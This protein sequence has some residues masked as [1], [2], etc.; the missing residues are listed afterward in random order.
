[1]FI[2]YYN[3]ANII[4]LLGLVCSV[5]SCY[6][7]MIGQL[8]LA[9]LVFL[10]AGL[11][12]M[13]DGRIARK[14]DKPQKEKLFGVQIDSLC[15]M[16][17]FGITPG[18]IAYCLGFDSIIDIII[19]IFFAICGAIRL[20]YFNTQALSEAENFKMT[21]FTGVPIPTICIILPPISLI[22]LYVEPSIMQHIFRTLYVLLAFA[23]ICKLK[24]K[25]PGIL[26][27]IISVAVLLVCVIFLFVGGP[28]KCNY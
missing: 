22:M 23:F 4:T 12:D 8:K 20:A 1:M 10:F 5:T 7:A 18:I 24:I 21:H 27:N 16:V 15:D 11:C 19:Y 2:G 26:Y 6:L 17:S 14:L 25:K 9:I 13:F 28:L 3:A